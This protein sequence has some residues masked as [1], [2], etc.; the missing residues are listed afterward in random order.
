[1][2][3]GR[4]HEAGVEPGAGVCD[5]DVH[6]AALRRAAQAEDHPDR[7]HSVADGVGEQLTGDE[8]DVIVGGAPQPPFGQLAAESAALPAQSG[9]SR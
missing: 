4:A 2:T 7:R 6:E 8:E 1:M 5:L 3:P 9:R